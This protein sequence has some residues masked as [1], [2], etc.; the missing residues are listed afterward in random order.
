MVRQRFA[1]H[2]HVAFRSS[3]VCAVA[4][5]CGCGAGSSNGLSSSLQNTGVEVPSASNSGRVAAVLAEPD[6]K[7]DDRALDG[8]RQAA[9]ILAYL[10]VAPGMDVAVLAPGSGYLMELVAR[11]VGID[12]RLYARNPPALVQASGLGPAWDE[13]LHRPAGARVVR[14]DDDLARPLTVSGLALVLLD[15][16]YAELAQR[17]VDPA[18]VTATAWNALRAEGRYVVVER[19]SDAA[20]T[21]EAIES[22]GFRFL[23]DGRFLRGGASPCDWNEQPV[24]GGGKRIF[25]TFVK[26]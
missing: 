16:E 17:G 8:P 26:P 19:E 18:A 24:S 1:F 3:V 5:L 9:E 23:A 25:L 22:H 11:S 14:I 4:L 21:R 7:A 13:R 12:G 10:D 20:K 6:R 15:H 2:A